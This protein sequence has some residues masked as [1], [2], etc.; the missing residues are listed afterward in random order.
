MNINQQLTNFYASLKGAPYGIEQ[1]YT[2]YQ[3]FQIADRVG[4]KKGVQGTYNRVLKSWADNP[5][6]WGE[7]SCALNWRLWDLAETQPEVAKLY[8]K[9]WMQSQKVGWAR[10]K[11]DKE[12]AQ[13][14]FEVTD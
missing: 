3:D 10:G 6:A 14:Y 4:G 7:V 5:R 8:E 13:T 12:Y 11:N 1:E 2:F 9:L